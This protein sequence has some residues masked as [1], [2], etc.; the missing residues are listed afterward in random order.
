MRINKDTIKQE[1]L[2]TEQYF[3]QKSAIYSQ[4]TTSNLG[5]KQKDYCYP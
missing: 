3:S 5:Q 2:A 1:N 4:A